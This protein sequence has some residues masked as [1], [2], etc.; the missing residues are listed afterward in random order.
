MVLLRKDVVEL[1]LRL[2]A[3]LAFA[4]RASLALADLAGADLLV[5]LRQVHRV[6]LK[7]DAL[8][9]GHWERAREGLVGLA[10]NGEFDIVHVD[11]LLLVVILVGG[12]SGVLLE[13]VG[14]LEDLGCVVVHE[15]EQL[16]HHIFLIVLNT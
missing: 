5:K 1:G 14:L 8:H 6:L 15:L 7:S 10:C 3:A 13:N 2:L 4:T 12:E 11:G 9:D 16:V